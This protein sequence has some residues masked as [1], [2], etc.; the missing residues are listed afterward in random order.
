ME[1]H[2]GYARVS[3]GEQK[4]GLQLDALKEAGCDK[5]FTDKLSGATA[6]RPGLEDAIEYARPGAIHAEGVK[7]C[8]GKA[9]QHHESTGPLTFEDGKE[10]SWAAIGDGGPPLSIYNELLEQT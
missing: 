5:I 9:A 7:R 10:P 4:M 1:E 8:L 3:T 2:V 6:D